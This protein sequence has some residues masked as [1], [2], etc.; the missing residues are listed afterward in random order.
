MEKGK[1]ETGKGHNTERESTQH[2]EKAKL[3]TREKRKWDRTCK[4]EGSCMKTSAHMQGSV[5][6]RKRECLTLRD[7]WKP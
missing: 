3:H 5:A 1:Q 4:T 2:R 6:E 7:R